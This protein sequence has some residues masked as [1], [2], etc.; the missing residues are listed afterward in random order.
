MATAQ[1]CTT[2]RMALT[3]LLPADIRE[4]VIGSVEITPELKPI[5]EPKAAGI[6][7]LMASMI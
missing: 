7:S 5:I 6:N 3:D 4:G 1:T 2:R